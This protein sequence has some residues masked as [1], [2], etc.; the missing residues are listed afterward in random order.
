MGVNEKNERLFHGRLIKVRTFWQ[1]Y[2]C[3]HF[4]KMNS[5]DICRLRSKNKHYRIVSI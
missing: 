1:Y 5:R 4:F 2:R 3:P